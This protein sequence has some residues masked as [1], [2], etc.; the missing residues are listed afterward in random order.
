MSQ[1]S[2]ASTLQSQ[3]GGSYS[4]GIL[5]DRGPVPVPSNRTTL[6]A[7]GLNQ[8]SGFPGA[9]G[10]GKEKLKLVIRF[11]PPNIDEAW[12]MG[13]LM[14]WAN[15]QT[16][17]SY[18][19]V[20]GRVSRKGEIA[21]RQLKH[22]QQRYGYIR[23]GSSQ[24]DNLLETKPDIYSRL[25]LTMKNQEALV[26]LVKEFNRSVVPMILLQEEQDQE[27]EDGDYSLTELDS[28]P[29]KGKADG[30]RIKRNA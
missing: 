5:P 25:Y 21:R 1:R 27:D 22:E 12:L 26:R 17:Q 9:G 24:S 10:S 28:E 7:N 13:F 20:Q 6:D 11:L 23:L 18:Y 15:E 30:E 4:S 16:L 8:S 2:V 29:A 14:T 3:R 19:F